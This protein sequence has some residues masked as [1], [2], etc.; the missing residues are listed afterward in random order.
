MHIKHP[1]I[2][3][4]N[5][6][7]NIRISKKSTKLFTYLKAGTIISV[8]ALFQYRNFPVLLS[9]LFLFIANTS[10]ITFTKKIFVGN[11]KSLK[12]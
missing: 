1:L 8:P 2:C 12:Q 3:S 11:Q 4:S 10:P 7:I 5:V 6:Q 9:G